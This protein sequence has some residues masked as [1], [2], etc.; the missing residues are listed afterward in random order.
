M[1]KPEK[2]MLGRWNLKKCEMN[3]TVSVFWTNSDHCGD[4]LC[5]DVKRNKNILDDKLS[6][7]KDSKKLKIR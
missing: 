7:L 1:I 4:V 5:G 2:V 3:E 6:K